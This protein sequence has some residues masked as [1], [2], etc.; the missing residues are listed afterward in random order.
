MNYD[1]STTLTILSIIV[2]IPFVIQFTAFYIMRIVRAY[3]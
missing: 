3:K 2:V 1:E